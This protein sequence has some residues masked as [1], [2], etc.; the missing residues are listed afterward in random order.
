MRRLLKAIARGEEI[1]QDVST[2]ENPAILEQL[3]GVDGGAAAALTAVAVRKAAPARR[4]RAARLKKSPNA[5]RARS[6]AKKTARRR[7]QRA[8][9]GRKL[10]VR[11]AKKTRRSAPRKVAAKRGGTGR[12]RR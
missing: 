5:R 9:A 7:V 1:T 4:K 12:R 10:R 6:Q 8:A 3:R 2:L 11:V